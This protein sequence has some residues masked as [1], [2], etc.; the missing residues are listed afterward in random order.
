MSCTN[1]N[2]LVSFNQCF[3][4]SYTGLELCELERGLKSM[5]ASDIFVGCCV[6]AFKLSRMY[7][8]IC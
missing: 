7:K 8:C 5:F 2:I 1:E 6:C 3:L 4:S